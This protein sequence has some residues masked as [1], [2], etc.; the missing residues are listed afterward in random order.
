[1]KRN[2]KQAKVIMVAFN[3]ASRKYETVDP[4][5]EIDGLTL[6][7]MFWCAGERKYMTV[8]GVVAA[9]VYSEWIRQ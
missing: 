7:P 9:D 2:S 6:V 1:M 8:P 4:E 3:A 5:G